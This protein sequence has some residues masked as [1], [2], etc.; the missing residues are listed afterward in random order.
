MHRPLPSLTGVPRFHV[1][2]HA[3]PDP[4]QVP[5]TGGHVSCGLPPS[6][7]VKVAGPLAVVALKA[8]D[9]VAALVIG[10]HVVAQALGE[11]MLSVLTV[12]STVPEPKATCVTCLTLVVRPDAV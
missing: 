12:G 7:H 8:A 2:D 10:A 3:F 1:N 11:V 9:V 4:L 6:S 5:V